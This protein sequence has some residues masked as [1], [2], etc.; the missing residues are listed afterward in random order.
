M[1]L[2]ETKQLKILVFNTGRFFLTHLSLLF[3]LTWVVEL[4]ICLRRVKCKGTEQ[5][6]VS[7]FGG[8]YKIVPNS[9]GK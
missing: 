9:H 5:E 8:E 7:C 2:L 6:I 4:T 3:P 1:R